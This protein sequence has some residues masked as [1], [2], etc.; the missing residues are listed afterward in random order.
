MSEWTDGMEKAAAAKGLVVVRPEDNE[1][2]IDIDSAADLDAF[3]KS[4]GV[5]GPLVLSFA[6]KPSPS[7]EKDHWH[8]VVTL[9]RAVTSQFER[10]MLQVLLGSDRLHEA[11]CW[12]AAT[13]GVPDACVFF[14]KKGGE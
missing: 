6:R 10:I 8:I 11:L 1:L 4:I 2:F 14:E 9:D 7:G 13:R 5:L 3:H 12:E